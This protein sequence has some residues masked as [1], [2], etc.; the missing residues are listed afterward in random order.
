MVDKLGE[1]SYDFS[2]LSISTH[3]YSGK[4]LPINIQ[5]SWENYQKHSVCA[6]NSWQQEKFNQPPLNLHIV[7]ING[8]GLDMCPQPSTV[9]MLPIA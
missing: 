2:T 3:R 6:K 7:L 8:C 1:G 5:R 4:H 9:L